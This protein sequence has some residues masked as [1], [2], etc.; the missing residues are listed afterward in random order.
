MVPIVIRS[1][2]VLPEYHVWMTQGN[3]KV[4]DVLQ[5]GLVST[6]SVSIDICFEDIIPMWSKL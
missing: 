5:D 1:V 2:T 6:V 3:V 4:V